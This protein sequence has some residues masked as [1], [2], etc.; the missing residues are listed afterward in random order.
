MTMYERVVAAAQALAKRLRGEAKPDLKPAAQIVPDV[1]RLL[2]NARRDELLETRVLVAK[3]RAVT[4]E[5]NGH[6]TLSSPA[7]LGDDES[8]RSYLAG[9]LWALDVAAS[10]RLDAI[11][12]AAEM[13]VTTRR[14]EAI[15]NV[16]RALLQ[17]QEAVSPSQVI[18]IDE[19]QT[20]KVRRDEV[21]RALGEMLEQKLVRV[22][23]TPPGS[24]R[25]FK[26]YARAA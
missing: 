25:R 26:Y 15:Q 13:T 11:S 10:V 23:E 24:D 18:K 12:V 21:S 20:L 5:G 17:T 7:A 19:C 8:G 22:V 3:L 2:L 9:A 4:T 14:R 16:I 6:E 1:M